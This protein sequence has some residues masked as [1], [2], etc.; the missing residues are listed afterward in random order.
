MNEI[1][2]IKILN[3]YRLLIKFKDGFE[4]ELDVRPFLSKGFARELLEQSQFE[5]VFIEP[6]GGLA[7]PNGF[8]MCPNFLREIVEQKE[9]VV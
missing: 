2:N 6:G 7:W 8:D 5:K 4:G 3:N 9:N 1:I